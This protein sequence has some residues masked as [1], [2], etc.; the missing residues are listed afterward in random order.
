MARINGVSFC[1]NPDI[2]GFCRTVVDTGFDSLEGSRPPFFEKLKTRNVRQRF[3]AWTTELGLSLYGFDCWVD[4]LPYD[5]LDETIAGFEAAIAFAADLELGMLISHDPWTHDNGDRSPSECL[6]TNI[7]LFRRVAAMCHENSLR[8]V[9]EPHPDTLS[10][11]NNWAIDFVDGITDG[12]HYDVGILYDLCHYGVGQPDN[13]LKSIGTLGERIRHMHYCDGDKETYALHLPFGDGA[14]DLE[15]AVEALL[16]ISYAG[17]LTNDLYSNPMPKDSAR[18]NVE[19]V[20]EVETR[21][22]LTDS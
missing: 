11:D 7:D 20:R 10:M 4:V 15:A 6:Q 19:H 18:R 1:D 12:N 9:L 21:L 22:G 16:D 3:A 17:S 14:I 5:R 2:E 13:Y 8:L